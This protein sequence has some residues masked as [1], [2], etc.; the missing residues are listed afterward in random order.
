MTFATQLLVGWFD[1]RTMP[2]FLRVAAPGAVCHFIGRFVGGEFSIRDDDPRRLY[3]DLL[4]KA[5]ERTDWSVLGWALMSNHVHLCAVAGRD[6]PWRL[7]QPVHG[8]FARLLNRQQ[9]R[10]GSLFAEPFRSVVCSADHAGRLLAYLHNNPVRAQVV[11]TAAA[12]TWTSHR[13]YLGLESRPPWLRTDLGF[14]LAGFGSAV[15]G[16]TRFDEMV[17]RRAGEPRDPE[18]SGDFGAARR[19]QAREILGAP[20]ELS[21]PVL[22]EEARHGLAGLEDTPLRPRWEGSAQGVLSLVETQTGVPVDRMR[23]RDRARNVAAARRMAL[24]AWEWLGR[25]QVEMSSV[26][27]ISQASATNLKRRRWPA[28]AGVRGTTKEVVD[29]AWAKANKLR[30]G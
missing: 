16:R 22:L 8:P 15:G 19:A 11:S 4:G 23:S 1:N 6:P 17:R 14:H 5:V 28:R 9:E 20:I 3:L 13:V 21:D 7:L 12:S 30:V 24:L 2:W 10:F 26:L 29:M 25:R 27:G 18:L